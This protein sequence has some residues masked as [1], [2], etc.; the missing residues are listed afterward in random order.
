MFYVFV[1]FFPC[2]IVFTSY[3]MAASCCGVKK[4]KLNNTMPSVCCNGSS[5]HPNHCSSP[6]NGL[7]I[8]A[9]MCY[10]CFDVLNAHLFGAEL[11]RSPSFTN[12]P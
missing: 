11:P 1:I 10:F 4:Q 5:V 7:V 9:E 6:S 3:K 2:T 12:D 8:R